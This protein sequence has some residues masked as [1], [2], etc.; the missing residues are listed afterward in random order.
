[1][2][3]TDTNQDGIMDANEF[4]TTGFTVELLNAS[5]V[6]VNTLNV[7]N[8]TPLM[9]GFPNYN[10][11]NVSSGTYKLRFTPAT[12]YRFSPVPGLTTINNT[13]TPATA[14]TS[15]FFVSGGT[16]TQHAGIYFY[17]APTFPPTLQASALS[18]SNIRAKMGT[19]TWTRGNGNKVLIIAREGAPVNVTPV[20]NTLY[21]SAYMY[22]F[23]QNLG[24]GNFVVY[25]SN[26][27]TIQITDMKHSTTYHFAVFEYNDNP[28]IPNQQKYLTTSPAIISFTTAPLTDGIGLALS[29]NGVN[30]YARSIG[31]G[32]TD[33]YQDLNFIN[34]TGIFTLEF[35]LKLDNHSADACQALFNNGEGASNKGIF[36]AYDN[37][38][39]LSRSK[40][41]VCE[42]YNGTGTPIISTVSPA[43]VITDNE[44][45]HVALTGDATKI[46]FYVD[47]KEYLGAGTMGTKSIGQWTFQ[48]GHFA[49]TPL[50][51]CVQGED[52]KYYLKGT[53][54]EMRFWTVT[55][56]QPQIKLNM[57]LILQDYETGFYSYLQCNKDDGFQVD[58]LERIPFVA[59]AARIPSTAPAAKGVSQALTVTT[60]GTYNFN[61]A[62]VSMTFPASGTY[63]NGE[64]V[65]S[66]L[67]GSPETLPDA[68]V[69]Y[70]SSY[71]VIR[72]YGTNSTFS[73][74]ESLVFSGINLVA[75]NEL[76][77][78][79][80]VTLYKRP[81][82]ASG[83]NWNNFGG[84]ASASVSQQKITFNSSNN[85]VSFSQVTAGIGGTPLPL[86]LISMKARSNDAQVIELDWVTALET[87][88]RYFEVAVF[89][90][91]S[92]QP[93][94]QKQVAAKNNKY[95]NEYHE[96]LEEF[97]PGEYTVRLTAVEENNADNSYYYSAVVIGAQ[98][99]RLLS[100]LYPMPVTGNE[101]H[102]QYYAVSDHL[103]TLTLFSADGRV[104]NTETQKADTGTKQYSVN[105]ASLTPGIYYLKLANQQTEFTQRIIKP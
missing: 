70:P 96:V 92:E 27:N 54:D 32:C 5:N 30:Q 76:D 37:R 100:S 60:A 39:A 52:F 59:S 9:P 74:L 104:L 62:G 12:G 49:A 43:N 38:S 81:S 24:N 95:R 11:N 1:M 101:I 98:S 36:F 34:N 103:L 6:V 72:N 87:G 50:N 80:T 68:L 21:S 31:S 97:Q 2:V 93:I 13:T 3:F 41:L 14:T 69:N 23:G 73:P 84:A 26:G 61:T 35:W 64:L 48:D 15:S 33:P 102:F 7:V 58:Q 47:G 71:W 55:R 88:I 22:G 78:A 4:I 63:P 28:N 46:R 44:W 53:L 94:V 8:G 83:S 29:F 25:A 45:H 105:T 99:N 90:K 42:L 75:A 91:G 79:G 65:V 40:Q 17:T 89:A 19:L 82:G 57:N 10:F 16:Y 77:P 86:T 51:S 66:K 56:T 20:N 18:V 67:T 85:I